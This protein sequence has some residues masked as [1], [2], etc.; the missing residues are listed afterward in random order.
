MCFPFIFS[1]PINQIQKEK[2]LESNSEEKFGE[3]N[4]GLGKS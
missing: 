3:E 4:Q 2:E 1:L